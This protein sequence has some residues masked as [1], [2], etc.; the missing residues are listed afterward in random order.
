MLLKC[1]ERGEKK[2]GDWNSNAADYLV[3]RN[4]PFTGKFHLPQM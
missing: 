2:T 3:R 4:M 1:S